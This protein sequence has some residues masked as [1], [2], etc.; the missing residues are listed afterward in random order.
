MFGSLGKL[1]TTLKTSLNTLKVPAL[2]C[3]LALNYPEFQPRFLTETH[4]AFLDLQ[5]EAF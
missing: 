1:K 5:N 4:S 2:K 3:R